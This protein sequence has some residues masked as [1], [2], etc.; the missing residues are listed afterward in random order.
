MRRSS[1]PRLDSFNRV[2]AKLAR[3][4]PQRVRVLDFGVG[5]GWL[6]RQFLS[7]G[8]ECD[9]VDYA[10]Q[11]GSGVQKQGDTLADLPASERHN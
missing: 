11:A 7:A 5:D 4:T 10:A 2:V 3:Q 6:M 1:S 9:L 8:C